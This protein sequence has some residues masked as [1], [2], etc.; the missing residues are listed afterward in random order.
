MSFDNP[1]M[2]YLGLDESE[3][4]DYSHNKIAYN[5][6]MSRLQ[7]RARQEAKLHYCYHCKKEVTSFC[8]SHSVPQF[9]LRRIA[10]DGKVYYANTLIDLPFMRKEQGINEAG[11]FQLICR[12]CDSKIFQQYE[13][14]MAYQLYPSGQMLAQIAMKDYLQMI[15]K[16]LHER[17]LYGLMGTE[18]GAPPDYTMHNQ[19]IISLDLA[20]YNS[21]YNRAKIASLGNHDDWYY[22]C[23]YK[24]L[25]YT[26][27]IAFQGGIVM[28][29][30]FEDNLINDIYN[31]DP[32]YHTKEVHVAIFPLEHESV[33]MLFIDA[34]DKRYRKFYKEL[35]KLSADDQLSAI[36]YIVFSYSE[37]V[38]ISKD[39]DKRALTDSNFIATCRKSSI[40]VASHPFGDALRT[41]ID[42][43][44]LSMR[45]DI[46][47]LLS[48]EFSLN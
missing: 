32:S 27:P 1:E 41:S 4:K 19:E 40:A 7:A 17:A 43:F 16:R 20:E 21:S 38:Y 46:P 11:T 26:V 31:M 24:K 36:N 5:K 44:S 45:K 9:C 8:N 3:Q 33:V 29:C 14:P 22:L 30:D 39:I 15:Y 10:T 34:R 18:L 47:N 23:Y 25:N 42:E 2:L 28:I 37:N 6:R 13:D 35:N 48:K 12:D